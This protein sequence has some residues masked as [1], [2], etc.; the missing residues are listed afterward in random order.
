MYFDFPPTLYLVVEV[1]PPRD[2]AMPFKFSFLNVGTLHLQQE[3]S[4]SAFPQC[5]KAELL[6]AFFNGM[7]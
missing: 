7:L 4:C 1:D 3:D 5:W 6:Q 2:N